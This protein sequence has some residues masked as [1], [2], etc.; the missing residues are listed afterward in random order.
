MEVLAAL[1][2]KQKCGVSQVSGSLL[3][4]SNVGM[5]SGRYEP[6]DFCPSENFSQAWET[7]VEMMMVVVMGAIRANT[8]L[9]RAYSVPGNLLALPMLT[10]LILTA[11]LGGGQFYYLHLY[12]WAVEHKKVN[13]CSRPHS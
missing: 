1:I 2:V 10:L 11:T 13:Y 5:C 7:T 12:R 8:Y 4:Y 6:C 9:S 3:F